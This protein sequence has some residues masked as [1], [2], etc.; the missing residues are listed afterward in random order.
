MDACKEE[1]GIGNKAFLNKKTLT[2]I[3]HD[4]LKET[5]LN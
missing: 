1:N 5:D 3:Y 4:C 2:K